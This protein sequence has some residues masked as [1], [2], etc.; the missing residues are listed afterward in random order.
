MQFVDIG[1]LVEGA[2]KGE[3]LG[4]RFLA[5][6]REVDA[7]VYVLRAFNDAEIPGPDDPLEHLRVLELELTLADLESVENQIAK[8]R[9]AARA[10]R[11][12]ADE[13]AALD[14]A[15]AS[16]AAGTPALPQRPRRRRSGPSCGPTS[17]SPTVRCWRW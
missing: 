10:D 16:L 15:E 5:N 9:K 8:R 6:I 13:V 17:C 7:V 1:G 3:G 11:A 2:S 14:A 4:N 12:L